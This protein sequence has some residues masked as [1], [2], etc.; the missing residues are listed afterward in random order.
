MANEVTLE[1]VRRY[2][3][4]S[5]TDKGVDAAAEL[6]ADSLKTDLPVNAFAD[7]QEFVKAIRGFGAHVL[8]ARILSACAGTDEAIMIYDLVLDSIGA[9]TVS[10]QFTVAEG[11][12][13]FIRQVRD[14]A[15]MRVEDVHPHIA[16]SF[17]AEP[18]GCRAC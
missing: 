3:E 13:S 16:T 6:L 4:A 2:H 14:T 18:A 10:E 15:T 5:T 9:V 12:I 7:E 17:R 11:A 1:P 8:S